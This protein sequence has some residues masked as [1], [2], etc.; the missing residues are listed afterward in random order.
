MSYKESLVDET[1]KRRL[2][3]LQI[4]DDLQ[5]SKTVTDRRLSDVFMSTNNILKKNN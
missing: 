4:H 2:S 3:F 1:K 5:L